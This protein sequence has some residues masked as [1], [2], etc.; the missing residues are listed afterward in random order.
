MDTKDPIKINLD[1]IAAEKMKQAKARAALI[2]DSIPGNGI[3]SFIEPLGVAVHP[4][5]YI[6][7][8]DNS[9]PRVQVKEET[10]TEAEAETQTQT[11][12][13]TER[14]RARRETIETH[15]CPPPLPP[16]PLPEDI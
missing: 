7:V 14:E 4:T 8:T 9:T 3:G 11:Q 13:Q 6:L 1:R 16:F 10:E 5:G 2:L 12:T 15:P